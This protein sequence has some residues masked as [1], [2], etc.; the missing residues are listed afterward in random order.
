MARPGFKPT[1]SRSEVDRANHYSIGHLFE[2]QY[3][4]HSIIRPVRWAESAVLAMY[5][6]FGYRTVRSTAMGTVKVVAAQNSCCQPEFETL[7]PIQANNQSRFAVRNGKKSSWPVTCLGT[8]GPL[9][10]MNCIKL[11]LDDHVKHSDSFRI[12]FES[13]RSLRGTLLPKPVHNWSGTCFSTWYNK[14]A[15]EFLAQPKSK[16]SE[17]L[18]EARV[19]RPD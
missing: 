6:Q 7:F 10:I 13:F 18:L 5:C 8:R 15:L 14:L 3:S 2:I 17:L 16:S 9:K 4:H 19:L 12:Y 11:I 1:I